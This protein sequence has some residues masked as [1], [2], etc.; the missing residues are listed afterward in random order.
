MEN[1][2]DWDT[3]E[4]NTIGKQI[5]RSAD[6][7]GANIAEGYGW[8]FYKDRRLFCFYSRGSLVETIHW[9]EKCRARDMGNDHV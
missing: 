6:S 8:F 1:G 9:L 4:K 5:V 3:F 2:F 7:I